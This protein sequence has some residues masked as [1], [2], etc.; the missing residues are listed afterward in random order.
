M[1]K[2]RKPQRSI[3][4]LEERLF[5]AREAL[6][7]LLPE[8]TYELLASDQACLTR[9]DVGKWH[10][11]VVESALKM[12]KIIQQPGK[13]RAFCPLCGGSTTAPNAQDFDFPEGLTIHL[14][15][16]RSAH[17]CAIL[18]AYRE[19]A[20]DNVEDDFVLSLRRGR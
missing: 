8:A 19:L 11:G 17:E 1:A 3:E 7:S 10:S 16:Q 15:G 20:L 4:E 6:Q 14:L 13:L 9:E 18:R 12:A 5:R 2:P